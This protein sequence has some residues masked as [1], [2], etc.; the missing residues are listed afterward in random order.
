MRIYGTMGNPDFVA[1][2]TV[3]LLPV[4]YYWVLTPAR[5]RLFMILRSIGLLLGVAALAATASRI[6]WLVL[7]LQF[8]F[9]L[10]VSRRTTDQ[11]VKFKWLIPAM[12]LAGMLFI[13]L[14]PMPLPVRSLQV[15][16]EGRLYLDRLTLTNATQVPFAGYGA[17]YY[18]SCSGQW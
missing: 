1:T 15:T 14:L 5:N 7:P 10:M 11:P 3:A 13:F 12:P 8:I 4:A 16:V 9:I 2:W 17:G 6:V 18:H